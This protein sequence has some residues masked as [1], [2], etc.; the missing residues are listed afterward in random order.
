M[1]VQPCLD[2]PRGR[3]HSP[4]STVESQRAHN[5]HIHEGVAEDDFVAFR[6]ARDRTLAMPELML[7]SLQV[8]LRAGKLPQ[9]DANGVSYLKIP[10]N[11]F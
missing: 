11:R 8:N 4:S 7:P 1:R 9:P 3:A 6:T 2:P 10:V 5:V